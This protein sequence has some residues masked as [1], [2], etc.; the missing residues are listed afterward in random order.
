[1]AHD[2]IRTALDAGKTLSNVWIMLGSG[3]SLEIAAHAGWDTVTIDLQ[4]GQGG[5]NEMVAM[6][7]AADAAKVPAMVRIPHNEPGY[8]HRALDAGVQGVI[9]PMIN[10]REDAQ[11]FANA[12]KYPP[13]G[14]RSWGPVRAALITQGDYTTL[15]N[16][17]TFCAAQI[18]TQ[19]ALD[20]IDEIMSVDGIDCVLVGPNDLCLSLTKG[21]LLDISAPVVLDALDLI[22]A[23]AKEHNVYAWCFANDADYARMVAKKGFKIITAGADVGFVAA[24][25]EAAL[26]AAF[27][28]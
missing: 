2:P 14:A 4:H 23:K 3:L 24:G 28:R 10:T 22:L 16:D 18:E 26:K 19:A 17:W 7:T 6:I 21:E 25:A 13:V 9:A 12:C 20:N 27:D 15:A 8:I 1:M 11:S 5:F